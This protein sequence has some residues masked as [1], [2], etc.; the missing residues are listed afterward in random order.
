MSNPTRGAVHINGPLTNISIAYMQGTDQYIA[1][2]VFPVVPVDHQSDAFYIFDLA[3]FTRDE[4]RPRA[5]G[6]ES[7]GGEFKISTDTFYCKV[8]AFHKDLAWQTVANADAQLNLERAATE[9]VT[10][11]ML[12]AKEAQ[13]I[14]SFM[15]TGVWGKD[16][17]GVASGSYV[18]GTNIIKWSDYTNSNPITDI[19]YY[20]TY[21]AQRTGF[22]PNK[23]VMS[24]DVYDTLKNHPDILDR[25]NGG[26]TTGQPAIV[27]RQMIAALFEVKE[28]LVMD[29]ILNSAK[30]GQTASYNF[31]AAGLML[32]VYA[33]D[34]PSL[35][36]PSGGYTFSWDRYVQ[37][38]EQGVAVKQFEME[39][40]ESDRIEGTIAFDQKVTGA[41]LG[42]FFSAVI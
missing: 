39:E 17:A 16:V 11:K 37:G 8:I 4:A 21:V 10:Q 35:M 6:T 7:A 42:V 36:A 29:A 5:P 38:N 22:R 27:V 19:S 2:K 26:A 41:P 9:Y 14:A 20:M 34:S 30:E 32:L 40:L 12:I 33:A 28:V 31:F 13:F 18:L 24:R 25:I 3:E 1:D 15:V 23:L